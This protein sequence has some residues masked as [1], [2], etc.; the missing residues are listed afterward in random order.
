MIPQFALDLGHDGIRLL[1]RTSTGWRELGNASLD[2]PDL[3]GRLRVLA[4]LAGSLAEGPLETELI[5]PGSQI[6]YTTVDIP[7][8][9]RRLDDEDIRT[10]L[11][12]RTPVPA[13][14][15]VF[16]W[17]RQ[18]GAI[19]VAVL[20]RKTLDEAEGFAAAHGLN[21]VSF[22]ARP[23][24]HEFPE[25]PDFGAT[26]HHLEAIGEYVPPAEPVEVVEPDETAEVVDVDV[27]DVPI[28]DRDDLGSVDEPQ[29]DDIDATEDAFSS[30]E[31]ETPSEQDDPEPVAENQEALEADAEPDDVTEDDVTVTTEDT[32][33]P[34]SQVGDDSSS[35]H[36]SDDADDVSADERKDEADLSDL[37]EP[38]GWD[39]EDTSGEPIPVPVA[40]SSSRPVDGAPVPDLTDTGDTGQENLVEASTGAGIADPSVPG[41]ETPRTLPPAPPPIGGATRAAETDGDGASSKAVT[42]AAIPQAALRESLSGSL[43]KPVIGIAAAVLLIG[44]FL[45]VT[46]FFRAPDLDIDDPAAGDLIELATPAQPGPETAS[47]T[48]PTL[49][50]VPIESQSTGLPADAETIVRLDPPSALSPSSEERGEAPFVEAQPEAGSEDADQV[51]EAP[52]EILAEEATRARYAATGIW[53]MAPRQPSLPTGATLD[54]LYLASID[55]DVAST[56][57]LLLGSPT[58]LID[59]PVKAQRPPPPIG[60]DFDFGTDGL[61][62]A[63]PEGVITPEG[64]LVTLGEPPIRP[65][66]RPGGAEPEITDTDDAVIVAGLPQT[67][68]RPR[69]GDL[70]ETNERAQLGGRTRAELQT[71]RPRERPISDQI[72]AAE[73]VGEAPTDRAIPAS[74]RAKG[75]PDN[76]AITV[77]AIIA[78]RTPAPQPAPATNA[79]QQPAPVVAA[80]QPQPQIPTVASVARQA[81]VESAINLRRLNLIGVYGQANDRR[82]LVRLPSG[83]YVKVQVGDRIDG[84]QVAA[85]GQNALRYT[86]GNRSILLEM[87][88]T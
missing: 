28:E 75:R 17:R 65:P 82:A 60:S 37:V 86:K 44:L 64:V 76:F 77:A 57:A 2:D 62:V 61:V 70:I 8:S 49:G 29:S 50:E 63:T 85:I 39:D 48:A 1:E 7:G 83:R 25:D 16:D 84:G 14:E 79:P 56:D 19:H 15:L 6:L 18:N 33:E 9:R 73:A 36:P 71:I 10:A 12:G 51:A 4:D 88:D 80:P 87:P 55:P 41:T 67:R 42:L 32:S 58:D 47:G 45:G 53:E 54:D 35:A 43:T 22:S 46:S 72:A 24:P 5:I 52:R 69:P 23:L 78:S 13:H 3:S 30:D 34:I 81:T 31:P 66:A 27:E 21:P 68:P 38:S 11:D 74:I 59:T 20:E 40:F 26:R